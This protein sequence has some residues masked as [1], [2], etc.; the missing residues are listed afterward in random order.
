MGCASPLKHS[1][2][3]EARA[4]TFI[5][6]SVSLLSAYCVPGPVP[7]AGGASANMP[8]GA[9]SSQSLCFGRGG[10]QCQVF[11]PA[12]STQ[13]SQILEVTDPLAA[14]T[15]PIRGNRAKLKGKLQKLETK[16][17]PPSRGRSVAAMRERG[18]GI[19]E[20]GWGQPVP[21]AAAPQPPLEGF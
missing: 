17:R 18:A 12:A 5:Q 21:A 11:P 19:P 8:G 6:A 4:R 2:V 1:R 3:P 16:Y 9:R 13:K 15:E 10:W 14:A 7:V 20:L